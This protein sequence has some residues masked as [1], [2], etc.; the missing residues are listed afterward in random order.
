MKNYIKLLLPFSGCVQ[1]SL[2]VICWQ[3]L[4]YTNIKESL[5]VLQLFLL[6][7]VIETLHYFTHL[8]NFYKRWLE[9][10]WPKATQM[11]VVQKIKVVVCFCFLLLFFLLC[12]VFICI[13]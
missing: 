13:V 11:Q 6:C 3:H 2:V 12:L 10:F 7:D 9:Y 1:L 4:V 5:H 8:C